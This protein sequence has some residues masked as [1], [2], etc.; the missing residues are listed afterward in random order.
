MTSKWIMIV[1]IAGFCAFAMGAAPGG[2]PTPEQQRETLQAEFKDLSAEYQLE[3][4]KKENATLRMERIAKRAGEV[5]EAL[6]KLEGKKDEG[7]EKALRE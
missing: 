6:K 3:A 7:K 5:Q 4:L 2:T 1:V